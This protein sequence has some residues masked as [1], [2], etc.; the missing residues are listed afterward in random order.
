MGFLRK[1]LFVATGGVSGVAGVKANSKKERTAKALEK[2]NQLLGKQS[3]K[4]V[5]KKTSEPN[6]KP[7]SVR[8]TTAATVPEARFELTNYSGG[9]P[10][11]PHP[12]AE[13]TLILPGSGPTVGRWELHWAKGSDLPIQHK[14]I[15]GGLAR[16][17]LTV[18]ATGP[19]SCRATICDALDIGVI[20]KFEL[21][22]AGVGE[23]NAALLARAKVVDMGRR[24]LALANKSETPNSV[25]TAP[26]SLV[27]VADELAKLADLHVKGVLSEEEFASQ[28]AKLLS[29]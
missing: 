16:Y 6:T 4:P 25:R 12:E 23:V 10:S 13:G 19:N 18:E 24:S 29:Q 2:Q 15:H 28:K 7:T 8:P 20:G 26:S 9:L 17:P 14:L 3:R 5:A 22:N 11:H 27:G 21:P 1:G